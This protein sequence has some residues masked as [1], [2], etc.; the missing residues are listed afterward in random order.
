MW[1]HRQSPFPSSVGSFFIFLIHVE[2]CTAWTPE[3]V[4]HWLEMIELQ[5]YA[6]VVKIHNINGEKS[7]Y[8]IS[9]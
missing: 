2:A 3:D 8:R 4:G 1:S 9:L 5:Q 7:G 6:A